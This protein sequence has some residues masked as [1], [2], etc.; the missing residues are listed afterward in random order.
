MIIPHSTEEKIEK[1]SDTYFSEKT[2]AF[3]MFRKVATR[4]RDSVV[5]RRRGI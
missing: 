1:I 5:S 3:Q 2:S 4:F